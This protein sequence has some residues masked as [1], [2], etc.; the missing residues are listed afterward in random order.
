MHCLWYGPHGVNHV[1]IPARTEYAAL[2]GTLSHHFDS[3][4]RG[5]ESIIDGRQLIAKRYHLRNYQR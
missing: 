3:K 5:L 1:G 4:P 2:N